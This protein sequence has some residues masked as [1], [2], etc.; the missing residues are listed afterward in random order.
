MTNG[1]L[2]LKAFCQTSI[3]MSPTQKTKKYAQF[4]YKNKQ[5]M[6]I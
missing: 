5:F 1:R 3:V 6:L 4:M 2:A